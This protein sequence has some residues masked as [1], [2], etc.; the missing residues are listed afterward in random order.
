MLEIYL[1]NL[2]FK[3]QFKLHLEPQNYLKMAGKISKP[4]VITMEKSLVDGAALIL[5]LHRFE[6]QRHLI[7]GR[8]MSINMVEIYLWRLWMHC[9]LEVW[10]WSVKN[11][12]LKKIKIGKHKCKGKWYQTNWYIPGNLYIFIETP[13]HFGFS[14]IR[15]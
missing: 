3:I 13:P 7:W 2:Y 1:G 11:H 12:N 9:I 5:S 15:F 10:F 4:I 14:K 6:L 8:R